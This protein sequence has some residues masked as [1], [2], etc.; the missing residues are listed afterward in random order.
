MQV[1]AGAKQE[2]TSG[3]KP[4]FITV[5]VQAGAPEV[6]TYKPLAAEWEK[7]TGIRVEWVEIPQSAHRD[8][9]LM[10]F[11]SG[12]S[13]FDV[14]A[15]SARWIPEFAAAG[16]LEPLDNWLEPEKRKDYFGNYLDILSYKGQL[17]GI[18]HYMF[19]PVM[20]YRQ[21]LFKKYG[22]RI[23]T[24][25]N[26][27]TKDEFLKAS[28]VVTEK[29]GAQFFGT[30]IAAKRSASAISLFAE[31]IYREGGEI[32]DSAGNVRVNEPEAVRALQFMVDLVHKY[33]VAPPGALGF[34]H[35]DLF[36]MFMQGR[37]LAGINWPYAFSATADP[38]QSKVADLFSVT[39]PWKAERSTSIV[40]GYGMSLAKTSARKESAWDFIKFITSTDQQYALRKKNFQ[41]PTS[42]SELDMLTKDP[43]LTEL[44]KVAL[45]AMVK[46]VE[47][48]TLLP[49][50]PEWSEIES[51][52]GIALQEA[53]GLQKTPQQAMDD[54][55]ADILRILGK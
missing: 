55:K 16:Y 53:M 38:T 34:D 24:N 15:T 35:A 32:V 4:E 28:Q 30:L 40:G 2:K 41:A 37:L 42:Q 11:S 54:A 36:N 50:I 39:I 23:P 21:D 17:Y 6:T 9:L 20:Y 29:E 12:M 3:G 48:G 45:S 27:M 51:R 19:A 5:V 31:Y 1:F 26:P 18:P 13:T 8:Q 10:E 14:I 49:T 25:D 52:L 43:S 22:F 46:A 33:K 7:Q 44:Q 47:N